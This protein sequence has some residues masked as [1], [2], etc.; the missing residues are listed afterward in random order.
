MVLWTI[1]A[2]YLGTGIVFLIVFQLTTHR[3]SRRL[4]DVSV[5]VM[6]RL[7]TG[8]AAIVTRKIAV[9]ITLLYAW[10]LWPAILVSYI[11]DLRAEK[12]EKK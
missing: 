11:C 10:I 7:A 6:M 8:G 4:H 9:G 5:D 12:L 1:S 2:S 3:I